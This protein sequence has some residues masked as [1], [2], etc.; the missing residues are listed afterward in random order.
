MFC[1]QVYSVTYRQVVADHTRHFT[2]VVAGF[3]LGCARFFIIHLTFDG[4][5]GRARDHCKH[6]IQLQNQIT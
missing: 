4:S 5:D 6:I 2:R 1:T 3:L